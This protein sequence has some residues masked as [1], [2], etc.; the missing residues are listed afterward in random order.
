MHRL[1][2]AFDRTCPQYCENPYRP[3]D[4][5]EF[6][7][8]EVLQLEETAEQPTRGLCYDYRVRLRNGLQASGEV[9]RLADNIV[10]RCFAG[11]NKIPDHHHPRGRP[12]P[13][14]QRLRSR[15]RGDRINQREAGPNGPLGVIL[16]RCGIAEVNQYAIAQISGNEASEGAHGLGDA[17]LIGRN[18]LP[19]VFWVETSRQRRRADKV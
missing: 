1:E 5:L 3:G 9:R 10:L 12:Y 4:P 16:M 18:D 7:W 8:P 2:T 6:L 14:L 19:Q 15:E 13:Y 11:P 17:P